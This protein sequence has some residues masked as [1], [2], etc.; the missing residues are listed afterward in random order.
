MTAASEIVSV[1]RK[2]QQPT[3]TIMLVRLE[4]TV[5]LA[6][7]CCENLARV[8][9]VHGPH[10]AELRCAGCD[11][12]R[13]W[14]PKSA[15]T[16]LSEL[17]ARFGAPSEL[18]ILRDS[19]LGDFKMTKATYDNT[20]SGALFRNDRKDGDNDR[21]YSGSLNVRGVDYWISGWLKTSAKGIKYL[22]L[23]VKP[24]NEALAIKPKNETE[25]EAKKKPAE[26]FDDEIPF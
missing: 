21:D 8:R 14:L 16:F 20:N 5:D 24:K 15:M 11:R 3:F 1:R 17:A 25:S 23:A 13:G 26:S 12:H 6:N 19:T 10:A 4:R 9:P 7:P 2:R 22:S 18:L